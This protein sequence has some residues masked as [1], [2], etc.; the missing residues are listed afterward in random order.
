[1]R[2]CVTGGTGFIGN[3]LVHRLLNEG[4]TMRALA[5]PSPRADALEALGADVIRGDLSDP[6]AIDRAVAGAEVVYHAAA[7]VNPGAK[8][9]YFD[10]NVEGTK[11]VL[12]ACTTQRVGRVVYLSSIA[13]YGLAR[14]DEIID[15]NTPL[16]DA[17]EQ[18]EFYAQSK[19]AADEFAVSFARKTGFPI[20][21]LRPGIVYGAGKPLPVGLLGFR[22]GK[23][24]VAFGN[25]GRRLP[26]SYIENLIDA[27]QLTVRARNEGLQRYVVIDD[28]NLTLEQYQST[29]A[30][31]QKAQTVFLPGW[32]VMLAARF[33]RN[34][35][36]ISL[37]QVRRALQDR[38]Y[39]S[40]RIRQELG[41][42]PKVLLREA[43][44]RTLNS[45]TA[46]H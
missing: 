27:I 38:H 31:V 34:G 18:R 17:H 4:D 46:N 6:Q 14:N 19:I 42:A 25:S 37:Q 32:P 20:V 36:S 45:T 33:A 5:R 22:F 11:N 15:E 10:A 7:Q 8:K 3:A 39:C 23:T 41:W 21:V 44:S 26:L 24:D 29:R 35:S 16:D 30:E 12:A 43:I 9:D 1:M 13:V 40:Q 28:E 2:V